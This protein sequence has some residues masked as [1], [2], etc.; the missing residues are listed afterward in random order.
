MV[1]RRSKESL[2]RRLILAWVLRILF[3][4]AII[5]LLIWGIAFLLRLDAFSVESVEVE[6]NEFVNASEIESLVKSELEGSY[7]LIV[8]RRNVF[9]YPE[10]TIKERIY[11]EFPRVFAVDAESNSNAITIEI[12]ERQ[13][14]ALWCEE[15]KKCF[16]IDETGVVF[17]PAPVFS[18]NV[19]FVFRGLLD[20]EAALGAAYLSSELFRE[21]NLFLEWLALLDLYPSYLIAESEDTFT[22]HT[23]N[24]A[25]ILIDREQTFKQTFENLE[26]VLQDQ[27]LLE[28]KRVEYANLD[29]IDLR[30]GNKVFYKLKG[31]EV[32]TE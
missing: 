4:V 22:I 5:A 2:R 1:G 16:F 7:W 9:F 26:T 13:P 8:P 6:G 24:G 28:S 10:K 3:Y 19:F 27:V 23:T 18:D 31:E 30:F 11:K 32:F 29:Y 20:A 15:E 17:A 25:D 21:I 12:V 14:F